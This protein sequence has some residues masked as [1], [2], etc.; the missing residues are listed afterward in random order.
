MLDFLKANW[1]HILLVIVIGVVKTLIETVPTLKPFSKTVDQVLIA[2]GLGGAV[3]LPAV[4]SG[5]DEPK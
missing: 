4:S 1:K 5:Q 2:L 3:S